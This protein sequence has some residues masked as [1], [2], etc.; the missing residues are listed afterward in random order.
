MI[1]V[2]IYS[3]KRLSKLQ[4]FKTYRSLSLTDKNELISLI[5]QG[6]KTYYDSY[7]IQNKLLEHGIRYSP[8]FMRNLFYY[9][10]KNGIRADNKG[11]SGFLSLPGM[12]FCGDDGSVR[13]QKGIYLINIVVFVMSIYLL[14]P[15]GSLLYN[16]IEILSDPIQDRDYFLSF[17][18]VIQL[19]VGIVGLG[20]SLLTLYLFFNRIFPA[21]EFRKRYQCVWENRDVYDVGEQNLQCGNKL[22]KR[23]TKGHFQ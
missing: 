6:E 10:Y 4:I 1:P 20:M 14:Y 21:F 3:L 8:Q 13:L 7:I 5:Y 9:T 2:L 19:M 12:F 16:S 15:A 22:T 23:I 18:Q 11:L 17:L